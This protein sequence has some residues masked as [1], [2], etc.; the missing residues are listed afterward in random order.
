MFLK[1]L[2]IAT[3]DKL[4]R[5]INFR[6]GIN[7]I[8]DESI[9]KITGNSVG[10]TTILKLI[11]YCFGADKKIIWEDPENK[12]QDYALVKDFL[13][14]NDVRIKLTL[15]E[16]LDVQ[17]SKTVIIERNF[18]SRG[19]KVIRRIDG[20]DVLDVDFDHTL[21]MLFF[22]SH[23][24]EKPTFRQIV[25]HNI[26]YDDQSLINTLRTLSKFTSDAEYETL[27]LFLLGCDFQRGNKKQQLLE[28]IKQ[29]GNFKKRLE[30]EQTR[31]GLEATLA[32]IDQEI[33]DLQLQKSLLNVNPN[34]Q[35]ELEHLNKVKYGINKLIA[36]I[37]R[38]TIRKG[39]IID[40]LSELENSSSGID[41]KQL[42]S[43]YFQVSSNLD[44]IQKSFEDL[45][46]FHNTMLNE[47]I[48]FIGAELPSLEREINELNF[49]LQNLRQEELTLTTS[50]SQSDTYEELEKIIVEL[51]KKH[52][53]KGEYET[54]IEQL[55]NVDEN[56]SRFK[57]ELEKID[58]E[59]FSDEFET[60]VIQQRDK[61]NS[62]LSSVSKEL[63]GEKY[64]LKYDKI[65]NKQQN[66]YKFRIFVPFGPNIGS[67]KKQGEISSF[68]I[69]YI[70]FA[71]QENM[72]CMHFLLNDKKELMHDNQLIK[73][74]K[75]VNK[76][77]I[78]F[79]ASILRDKLPPELNNEEM[80]IIKL[81][82]DDKL[83]R[84]KT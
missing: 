18:I 35:N 24:G 71:D 65:L 82:E 62:I 10:K 84:I 15:A 43:F 81:S 28:S 75:I 52:E 12:K 23:T 25:S 77:N 16:C 14:S 9:G 31:S 33:N 64:A 32:I 5:T 54:T 49:Q 67:G 41:L 1:N 72:P 69:S 36:R 19:K 8:V 50:L 76:K 61:F 80:I 60:I 45:L 63:Y 70:L 4:I 59:L 46:Q 73:I 79:I 55:R 6:K 2:E 74:A 37:G 22:P 57:K 66:L 51:N 78:Q 53:L 20:Q 30:R 38:L 56:I 11:D 47:K 68:D 27:H 42:R 58:G 7:F 26:R 48:K 39:I 3:S 40:S 21:K 13:V 44:K 17:D 34:F 29:E 83:F